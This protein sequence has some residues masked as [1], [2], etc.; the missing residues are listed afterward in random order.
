MLSIRR[1]VISRDS[2]FLTEPSAPVVSKK[3]LFYSIRKEFCDRAKGLTLDSNRGY[4]IRILRSSLCLL[5]IAALPPQPGD[6]VN[7]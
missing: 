1:L 2:F 5:P 7:L 6:R 4:S 3:R